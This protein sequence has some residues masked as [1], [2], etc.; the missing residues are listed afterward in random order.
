MENVRTGL[1]TRLQ[2]RFQKL[3]E[4]C[5]VLHENGCAGGPSLQPEQQ[6]SNLFYTFV[7]LCGKIAFA[8]LENGQSEH[9]LAPGTTCRFSDYT[10]M[11]CV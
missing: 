1:N 4:L 7:D 6:G 5:K 3:R 8:A 9:Q 11:N 10:E 2:T